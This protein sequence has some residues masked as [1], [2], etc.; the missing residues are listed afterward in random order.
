MWTKLNLEYATCHL[1]FSSDVSGRLESLFVHINS[2]NLLFAQWLSQTF[3]ALDFLGIELNHYTVTKK[4]I[5]FSALLSHSSHLYFQEG[6][7]HV[8]KWKT[9]TS[10]PIEAF[11]A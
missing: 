2:L 6:G 3:N 9:E 5:G 10:Q 11:R 4:G 7:F 8:P 1:T